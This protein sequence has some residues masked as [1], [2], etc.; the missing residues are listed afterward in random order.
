VPTAWSAPPSRQ[1][2]AR[3]SR[4]PLS[5]PAT[6]RPS[7]RRAT[8]VSR[9]ATLSEYSAYL[10]WLGGPTSG[11]EPLTCSLRVR[12]GTLYLSRKVAYLQRKG[13]ATY[14]RV[15]R[16]YAQVSVPVSVSCRLTGVPFSCPAGSRPL[17]RP[18]A[19]RVG[20]RVPRGRARVSKSAGGT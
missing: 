10:R 2:G 7:V 15:M 17:S 13:V 18:R 16:N 6:S 19:G 14:R 9:Y 11:L 3:Q 1:R 5:R 4:P 12:F 8:A 20:V